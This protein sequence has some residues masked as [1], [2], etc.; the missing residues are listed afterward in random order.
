[1]GLFDSIVSQA[2]GSLLSGGS[3]NAPAG[4]MDVVLGLLNSN[5]GG[6]AGLQGLVSSFA[7]QGLGDV[8]QS[9]IGT[10]ANLPISAEQIQSVLGS[11]QV[12][13]IAQQLGLTPDA[14]SSALAQF[15][16]QAVDTLTPNG[17]LDTSQ[18]LSQGL[19]MLK[20]FT[21]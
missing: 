13:G 8:V 5:G 18:L 19:S 7:S 15:L 4:M 12:Q 9:W 6:A 14:A 21:G 1:M 20:G 2:T 3:N 10:G 16:P 17:Q 11:A